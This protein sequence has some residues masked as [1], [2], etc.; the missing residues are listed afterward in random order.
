MIGLSV[1][2]RRKEENP[3]PFP[4][5]SVDHIARAVPRASDISYLDKG[6][7]KAVYRC[8]IEGSPFVLKFMRPNPRPLAGMGEADAETLAIDDVTARARREV[9]TMRQ[10][11]SPHLVKMGP[12][13]LHSVEVDG[14]ELICF[15]EEL[16]EGETLKA[17]MRSKQSIEDVV[18]LGLH[19]A[20]A[21][22]VLWAFEKIHRDI[23]P[24]NIMRRKATGEYVLLDMGLVFDL[25]DESWSVGP[26]G[27]PSYFSPE[28]MDFTN[29]RQVLDFR[30][31][32]FSLG[33]TMYQ[34]L[35]GAHPFIGSAMNSWDVF[36]NIKNM[37][38]QPP[39]A[40]RPD[41]PEGLNDVIMRLLGKRPALRY[42]KVS[43]FK[44]ALLQIQKEGI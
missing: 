30:S 23:K 36:Q 5:L 9:E 4:N 6:G 41:V 20:D 40:L 1:E 21:I 32:L 16:I 26:V 42:R 17:A 27:T 11:N 35:T 31:D 8:A 18:N 33:T 14:E 7:Q 12:V 38:P 19:V 39:N 15:S 37:A 43:L 29:R 25:N 3:M 28:Q 44:E 2:S 10:C 13:E 34:A 24:G 22:D